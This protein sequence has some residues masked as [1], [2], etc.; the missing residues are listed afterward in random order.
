LKVSAHSYI[1]AGV[2]VGGGSFASLPDVK[3]KKKD[4]YPKI[5]FKGTLPMT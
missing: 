5:L 4:Q 1:T 3:K 2:H